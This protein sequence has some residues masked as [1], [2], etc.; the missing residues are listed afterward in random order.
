M[1][2]DTVVMELP[3]Q[4][5]SLIFTLKTPQNLQI[6]QT[7]DQR[8][9]TLTVTTTE[10]PG[11]YELQ[12]GGSEGGIRRGFS[13]NV[14]E[15]ITRLDRVPVEDLD[16]LFGEERYRLA[17]NQE[18]ITRDVHRGRVG[19]ELFPF[20]I[21][22]VALVLGLEHVLANRFYRRNTTV[23]TEVERPASLDHPPPVSPPPLPPT[24]HQP[25]TVG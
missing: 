17:R 10:A 7:V 8:Q 21:V 23:A 16:A 6:P 13:A 22:L 9:G 14:P 18:E 2:G 15:A 24:P 4:Q 1:A 20:L 25:V 19:V 3:E 12:A 11:H 5:R